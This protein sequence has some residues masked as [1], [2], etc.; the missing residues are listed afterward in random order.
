MSSGA[1][2]TQPAS[3]LILFQKATLVDSVTVWISHLKDSKRE[4]AAAKLW[5]RYL[6]RLLKLARQKLAPTRTATADEED[7]AITAFAALVA[8][9]QDERFSQ[10]NDRD[11]LWQILVMLTERKAISQRRTETAA[12]R[13]GLRH[14]QELPPDQQAPEP[15]PELAAVL[16]EEVDCRLAELPDEIEREIA[17]KRLQG[18]SN[19]E[20]AASLNVGLRTVERKLK[21]IRR[22]WEDRVDQAERNA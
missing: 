18:F 6:P 8:G 10:L 20:I 12:K 1:T 22:T 19:E 5:D 7:V 4:Q 16:A 17:T 9:I 15:S 13:G 11:D 21:L 14:N 2:G 3:N